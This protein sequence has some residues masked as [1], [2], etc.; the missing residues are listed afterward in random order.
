MTFSAKPL[1]ATVIVSGTLGVSLWLLW[2]WIASA[3]PVFLTTTSLE[4]TYTVSLAGQ[5]DRPHLP[6]LM[7]TVSFRVTKRR[8]TFLVHEYLHSGDWFDPSFAIL[9]PEHNWTSENVLHLFRDE[10]F[11]SGDPIR[12]IVKNSSG[13]TIKYPLIVTSDAHLLF[14]VR[15]HSQ[16][17][18][19]VPPRRRNL[20]YCQHTA[21]L[22]RGPAARQ[23]GR[24]PGSHLLPAEY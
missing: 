20:F 17:E 11:R 8:E 10:Y 16:I 22:R 13:E 7:S 9:Y 5:K 19:K 21:R 24:K 15:S 18:L 14:D 1:A 3:G 12:L 4:Q 2:L 6:A 23:E